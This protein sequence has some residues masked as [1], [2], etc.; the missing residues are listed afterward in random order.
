MA[1]TSLIL[2][3]LL[4]DD[5]EEQ[6]EPRELLSFTSLEESEEFENGIRELIRSIY[7][8][9]ESRY[10]SSVTRPLCNSG[11]SDD[12]ISLTRRWRLHHAPYSRRR[13][14]TGWAWRTSRAKHT[15]K[16]PRPSI[17]NSGSRNVE[18]KSLQEVY[19]NCFL[20]LREGSK[21]KVCTSS[22]ENLSLRCGEKCDCD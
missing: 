8:V 13:R 6:F 2:I 20:F 18:K 1:A 4:Q 10:V 15:S 5:I 19:K 7:F 16:S 22:A 14:S 9:L 21:V 3:S 12:W 17:M 11:V